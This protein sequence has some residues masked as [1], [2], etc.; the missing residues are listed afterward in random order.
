MSHR[1]HLLPMRCRVREK[2]CCLSSF[3]PRIGHRTPSRGSQIEFFSRKNR[4]FEFACSSGVPLGGNRRFERLVGDAEVGRPLLCL[5]RLRSSRSSFANRCFLASSSKPVC[6]C[7]AMLHPGLWPKAFHSSTCAR[8]PHAGCVAGV[9]ATALSPAM[10]ARTAARHCL[11]WQ[12]LAF[13]RP[14]FVVPRVAPRR[15][16][17]SCLATLRRAP[18]C[19]TESCPSRCL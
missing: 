14:A 4:I 7:R 15:I 10:A 11:G 1:F 19:A 8:I 5:W 16:P 3:C 18:F 6:G 9:P 12:G 2:E 13:L 17:Y